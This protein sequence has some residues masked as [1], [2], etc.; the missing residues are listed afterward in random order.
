ALRRLPRTGGS[1]GAQ[2][3]SVPPHPETRQL[4]EYGRKRNRRPAQ[5]MPRPQQRRQGNDPRRGR[6]LATAAKRRRRSDPV[7]VHHRE[8]SRKTPQSISRQGVIISVE[9]Y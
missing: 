5:P 1:P 3:A 4:A 9:R 2:A 6:R 7:V 8:G